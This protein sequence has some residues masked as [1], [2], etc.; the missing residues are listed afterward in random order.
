MKL[1]VIVGLPRAGKTTWAR[2]TGYPIVN[3]DSIRLAL[4]GQRFYGPAE[5]F[6]WAMA[7]AMVESL[8]LAGHEHIVVD[9][10]N[11]SAKRRA[12]WEARYP[13]AVE[14]QVIEASPEVCAERARALNDET[15]LPVIARMSAE[16]DFPC[17]CGE[18]SMAG[19][20]RCSLCDSRARNVTPGTC[21][22]GCGSTTWHGHQAAGG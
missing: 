10:T 12:E 15:I 1:L 2:M 16:W 8:R 17:S 19:G 3:P 11:V 18:K 21:P 9:A 22:C 4:H 5:P 14:W 13:G 20:R 6:V 7:Y